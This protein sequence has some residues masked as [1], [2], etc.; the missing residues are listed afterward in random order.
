MQDVYENIDKCNLDKR[1]KMLIIFDDMIAD[2]I[3]NKKCNPIETE[4]FIRSK[5]W[6]FL[7]FIKHF[8][9]NFLKNQNLLY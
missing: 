2:M 9:F 7:F 8:L 6:T 1:Q 3:I 5:N 4:L